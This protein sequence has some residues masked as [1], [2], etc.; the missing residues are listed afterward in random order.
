MVER[1]VWG[2]QVASSSLAIPTMQNL[3]E[4][5]SSVLRIQDHITACDGLIDELEEA[6]S[7]AEAA[8]PAE[9]PE[10]VLVSLRRV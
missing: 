8:F 10:E 7:R 1:A 5:R 3:T 2:R 4:S 6:L 9:A